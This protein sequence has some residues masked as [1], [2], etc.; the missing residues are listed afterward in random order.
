[1]LDS[2]LQSQKATVHQRRPLYRSLKQR[3]EI[4]PGW[5]QRDT[6]FFLPWRAAGALPG[7]SLPSVAMFNKRRCRL[8]THFGRLVR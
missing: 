8:T 7:R 2:L 1:M 4:R 5:T 6:G 3:G